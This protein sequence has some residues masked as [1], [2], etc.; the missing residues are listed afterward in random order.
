[1]IWTKDLDTFEEFAPRVH[2][3]NLRYPPIRFRGTIRTT[4]RERQVAN[5]LNG[6]IVSTIDRLKKL[7]VKAPVARERKAP[8]KPLNGNEVK[9]TDQLKQLELK[10]LRNGRQIE[11]MMAM[12]IQATGGR[13]AKSIPIFGNKRKKR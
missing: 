5:G 11:T 1:M 6:R 4:T 10:V 8:A 3:P 12:K 7:K 2:N 13:I 9:F